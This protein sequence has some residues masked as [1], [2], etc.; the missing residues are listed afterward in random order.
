MKNCKKCK[1]NKQESEFGTE[2]K[3]KKV[4]LKYE[5]KTCQ[6]RYLKLWR[7]NSKIS[8]SNLN[9]SNFITKL[10]N[11]L[12]ESGIYAVQKELDKL[13]TKEYDDL[14]SEKNQFWLDIDRLLN[15]SNP[16]ESNYIQE[17]FTLKHNNVIQY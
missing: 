9:K 3:N 11:I 16:K 12:K 6:N 5:C 13:D 2:I 15:S 10:K 17:V 7:I 14:V 8:K 1:E 4:Y